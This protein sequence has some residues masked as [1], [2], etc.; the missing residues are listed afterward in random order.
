VT[1]VAMSAATPPATPDLGLELRTI[2]G[3]GASVVGVTPGSTAA[4]AG[5][6]PGDMITFAAGKD[7][8]DAP[9]VLRAFRELAPER[10]LLVGVTRESH[11]SVMA[12]PAR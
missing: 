5:F 9:T 11:H 12:L 4:R 2:R 7:A 8:P 1:P 6:R 10:Q 3:T